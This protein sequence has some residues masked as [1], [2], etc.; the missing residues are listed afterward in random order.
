MGL[1]RRLVVGNFNLKNTEEIKAVLE[2]ELNI[3]SILHYRG[4]RAYEHLRCQGYL[5]ARSVSIFYY[6]IGL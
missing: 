6:S 1:P 2:R 5:N 4:R 3:S